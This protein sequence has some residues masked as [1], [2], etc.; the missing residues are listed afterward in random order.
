MPIGA[1]V[2]DATKVGDAA[3]VLGSDGRNAVWAL[4]A[5]AVAFPEH[6]ERRGAPASHG[7]WPL[8]VNSDPADPKESFGHVFLLGVNSMKIIV[9]VS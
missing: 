6:A 9:K 5:R 8:T 2:P 1:P 7:R 4:V 3:T